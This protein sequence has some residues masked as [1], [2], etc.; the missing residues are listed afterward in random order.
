MN[1]PLVQPTLSD[2]LTTLASERPGETAAVIL[3]LSGQRHTATWDG[4]DR[5]AWRLSARISELLPAQ[6]SAGAPMVA[7]MLPTSL[8]HLVAFVATARAGACIF[9]VN[10]RTPRDELERIFAR[11]QPALVIGEG[12]DGALPRIAI[13]E[14]AETLHDG[15]ATPHGQAPAASPWIAIASSGSTGAPKLIVHRGVFAPGLDSVNGFLRVVGV[16]DGDTFLVASPLYHSGGALDAIYALY[17]GVTVMLLERFDAA[18]ALDA[19][20]QHHVNATTLVPTMMMRMLDVP[21][22]RER[23]YSHLHSLCHSAAPCPPWLKRAWIEILGPD[24]VLELYTGSEFVGMTMINGSEWLRRP[25]SVGRPVFTELRI[26]GPDGAELPAGAI[27]EIFMRG[28]TG[29]NGFEYLGAE[30]KASA[31]GFYS[32][33]DLGWLD[34]D[35]YL[36]LADRRT[37][38]IISGGSNVYPAEIESTLSEHPAIADVVVIGLPDA[39]WGQRVHAIVEPT[40]GAEL[41]PDDVRGFARERLTPYKVPKTVELIDAIPRTPTG[42][43]SRRELIAERS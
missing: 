42:K 1:V 22:A 41:G 4:V 17:A 35:G 26:A 7:I 9:P 24:R 34:E 12:G 39:E 27:G 30:A 37:D 23:D 8:E 29:S 31:D 38:L 33:G 36:Y 43:I 14:T 32:I 16:A 3:T 25:G 10:P 11:A 19:I 28:T 2:R 5:A 13:N 18:L 6:R 40:P 15:G 21:G 20:E